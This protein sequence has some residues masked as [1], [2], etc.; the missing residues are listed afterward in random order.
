M[1]IFFLSQS[2]HK[3][4]VNQLF[5]LSDSAEAYCQ[6]TSTFIELSTDTLIFAETEF[7]VVRTV[8]QEFMSFNKQ[9]KLLYQKSLLIC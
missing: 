7:L 1:K 5:H 4:F 8:S 6:I 2:K 9:M 3:F